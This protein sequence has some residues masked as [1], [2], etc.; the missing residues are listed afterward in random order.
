MYIMYKYDIIIS[1]KSNFQYKILNFQ[2]DNL[3]ADIFDFMG[4]FKH[5]LLL[6]NVFRILFL[7]F[8]KI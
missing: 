5:F 1:L 2:K 7:N 6:K 8:V 4:I 3:S